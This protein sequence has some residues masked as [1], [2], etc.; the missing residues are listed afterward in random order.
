MD[1]LIDNPE[2]IQGNYWKEIQDEIPTILEDLSGIV[3]LTHNSIEFTDITS[4]LNKIKPDR[5][6]NILYISLIRSYN[7]MRQALNNNPLT[8][9]RI[10]FIDCVSG[11]AFPPED[12]IDD[13]LYHIPPQNLKQLKEIIQY[14][15]EKSNS[16]IIVLDSLS[17][18][19]NFSK[20]TEDEIDDLYEFLASLRQSTLNIVQNT[21]ILLYDS[22]MSV[23][24]NLPK[25][26][27][28]LILKL[29]IMK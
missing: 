26:S 21:I 9:K 16:D 13:C 20:P 24:K 22:K 15:I 29:E 3:L 5:F 1:L 17:Q 23:M 2:S 10:F 6:S 7:Y 14:G 4:F 19:I 27:T 28:D 11:F 25:K 18:F 8:Q 12:N